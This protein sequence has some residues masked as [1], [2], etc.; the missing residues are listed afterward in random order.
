MV[1]SGAFQIT[2]FTE[3]KDGKNKTQKVRFHAD[4]L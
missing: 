1:V 2:V 3:S 4:K